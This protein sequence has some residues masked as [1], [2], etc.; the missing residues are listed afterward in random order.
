MKTACPHCGRHYEIEDQYREQIFPCPDC[1]KDFIIKD[2]VAPEKNC[3]KK[4]S[5]LPLSEKIYKVFFLVTEKVFCGFAW[6]AF[7][8]SFVYLIGGIISCLRSDSVTN[9]R[10]LAGFLGAF[11][12]AAFSFLTVAAILYYLRK[13]DENTRKK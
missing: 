6:V 10:Y 12:G 9:L 2:Y 7:I 4:D 5:S 3:K 1:G 11:L 8:L 13:I